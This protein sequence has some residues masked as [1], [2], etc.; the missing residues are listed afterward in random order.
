[1]FLKSGHD[2]RLETELCTLLLL[3]LRCRAHVLDGGVVEG[4]IT[5]GH[6]TYGRY[7]LY[8]NLLAINISRLRWVG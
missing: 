2:S 6:C 7:T 3:S 8:V 4:T 1:M 5:C